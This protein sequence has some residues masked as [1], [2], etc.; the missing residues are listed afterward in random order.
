MKDSFNAVREDDWQYLLSILPENWEQMAADSSA[1]LRLRGFKD[2]GALLRTLLIH[3]L[4]GCSLRETATHARQLGIA[5]ISDV[6]L[7]KRLNASGEW[8]R[9]MANSLLHKNISNESFSIL[10]EGYD[11]R[12]VDATCISKPG[13]K[14]TD[15]RVHYCIALPTLDC[16][17]LLVT[18]SSGGETLRNFETAPNKLFIGDR[19]Y[20]NQSGVAYAVSGGAAVLIRMNASNLPLKLIGGKNDFSLLKHLRTL[21]GRKIG[22]WEVEFTY[23]NILVTGRVCAIK[24]SAAAAEIA[25]EKIMREASKKQKT[26]KPET[27]EA[28]HYVFVFTTLSKKNLPAKKALKVYRGRWQIELAFKRLKSLLELGQLPKRDPTGAKAWIHGK[29]FT[30]LLVGTLMTLA[31]RFSPWGYPI[32]GEDE[33]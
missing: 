27:I 31:E 5:N 4:D 17:Q 3:F 1:L 28:A 2:A 21:S 13:S 32:Q 7:L 22:D 19:G 16:E 12:L 29:L 20:S 11:V 14:G 10:P 8:F 23:N 30:A 6:A 18:D 15:W 26:P 9:L 33:E 24:K 25:I